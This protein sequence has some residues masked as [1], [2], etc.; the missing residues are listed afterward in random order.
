MTIGAIA[1]MQ[2]ILQN[3]REC[4]LTGSTGALHKHH[5]YFGNPNRKISEQNGF[6][7][8]LKPE[9]HNMS[10]MGVHFNHELDMKLKRECQAKFEKTH[11][12]DEFMMLIGRNYL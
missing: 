4:Y 7:V 6:W 1:S 12:R 11:T 8:Y 3:E 9:L 2:S 10:K 5:I